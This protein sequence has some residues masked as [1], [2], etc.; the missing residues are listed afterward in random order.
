I[1]REEIVAVN[2]EMTI[3]E[4]E[5]QI[6]K[7]GHTRMPVIG[8][9]LDDIIG[10]VHAKDLLQYGPEMQSSI[11]PEGSIRELAIVSPDITQEDALL[12]MRSNRNHLVVLQNPVSET[13][14][15]V[16][17]EDVVEELVGEFED[18]TDSEAL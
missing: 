4:I 11:L 3:A 15:L 2:K 17:M 14:G 6:L 16:T 9:T 1:P 5:Q 10:M 8:E 7:S 12:L 13:V 18:E